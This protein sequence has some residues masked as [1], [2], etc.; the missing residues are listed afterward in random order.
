MM[1][2]C[3]LIFIIIPWAAIGQT[4]FRRM[5]RDRTSFEYLQKPQQEI[6][7][8]EWQ[9][10]RIFI[11]EE[12]P[13]SHENE[14]AYY[15]REDLLPA[16][17][18]WLTQ[19]LR[20]RRVHG[21]LKFK[22]HCEIN[23]ATT[24]KCIA[25]AGD[26]QQC[27][28]ATIPADHF[29][30]RAV[31][32]EGNLQDC[33]T[34][35]GGNGI[36]AADVALYVTLNDADSCTD[37]VAAFAGACYQDQ[38]DRPI[39]AYLNLCQ[40]NFFHTREWDTHVAVILREITGALA[41][42][43]SLFP[44]FRDDTGSPRTPRG[45]GMPPVDKATG[46]FI[47]SESTLETLPLTE[48]D[49]SSSHHIRLPRV[50]QEARDHFEC[51]AMHH[52]PCHGGAL[53][54]FWDERLLFSEIMTPHAI[55][56]RFSRITMALLHDT[57]WYKPDYDWAGSFEYGREKG[58]SF[59]IHSCM[60]N[61]STSFP[62]T[63][64]TEHGQ[65]A[66]GAKATDEEVGCAQDS[67][68]KAACDSCLHPGPLPQQLQYFHDP[69]MGGSQKS[70]QYCP[71]WTPYHPRYGRWSTKM[72]QD[73]STK[74]NVAYGERFGPKSR[75]IMSSA[76][77]ASGDPRKK[78]QGT[79]HQVMCKHKPDEV[80]IEVN[81]HWV[82]CTADE[83]GVQKRV[84]DKWSG[85]VTCPSFK[86]V[87]VDALDEGLARVSCRF[88][89]VQRN[90]RCVCAAG[91]LNEDCS[92][93]DTA[94]KRKSY[95]SECSH[96]QKDLTFQIGEPLATSNAIESWPLRPI[97]L[98]VPSGWEGTTKFSIFPSLPEGLSLDERDGTLVGTPSRVSKRLAY[99]LR[100][101][102]KSSACSTTLFITVRF[103]DGGLSE[104]TSPDTASN[105]FVAPS[106]A[107]VPLLRVCFGYAFRKIQKSPG[108]SDFAIAFADAASDATGCEDDGCI[109]KVSRMRQLLS[110]GTQ[111][112][113]FI[114]DAYNQPVAND[115]LLENLARAFSESHGDFAKQYLADAQ[116]FSSLHGDQPV[117]PKATV[118]EEV[119]ESQEPTFSR[120]FVIIMFAASFCVL[121]CFANCCIQAYRKKK[122][123]NE[124][125]ETVEPHIDD[126]GISSRAMSAQFHAAM[127]PQ[128]SR[129]MS[130]RFPMSPQASRSMSTQFQAQV[131]APT[132]IGTPVT[133]TGPVAPVATPGDRPQEMSDK[134]ALMVDM[135]Y[136]RDK[137]E[138]ALYR[139]GWD[140]NAAVASLA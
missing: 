113:F 8:E 9:P 3:T 78:I 108:F 7:A 70:I 4:V 27:G 89:G 43:L 42:S 23:D 125:P 100:A 1:I 138:L 137:A 65:H 22:P 55:S 82:T 48:V 96:H 134:L 58:C 87:C 51:H 135:G 30:D 37:D 71:I 121:A 21:N 49:L 29:E 132:V 118:D 54:T 93:M 57:G 67:M 123:M 122:A 73:E 44:F 140:I 110:G 106:I 68:G 92:V 111:V 104:E 105:P 75:C 107:G 41:F 12:L 18:R 98:S 59:V 56:P 119:D 15:I 24:G 127:S 84:N 26:Y 14:N 20:T 61:G 139:N 52:V 124:D 45:N 69:Q 36:P 102:S 62:D 10:I 115:V 103:P 63:F 97:L 11:H 47:A 53:A 136:E 5:S 40:A 31:C 79:C 80:H 74:P 117:K 46:E 133:G 131:G 32:K 39:A 86:Q 34:V 112:E 116:L 60:H 101:A 76:A 17:V 64:C 35:K 91:Y 99:S 77:I 128:G 66:C 129:S 85:I 72:C 2:R 83:V 109:I 33:V 120:T 126:R 25:M 81:P 38:N 90:R 94:S 88:P 6:F 16:V 13:S 28:E 19:I 95:P 114:M 130:G 50:V